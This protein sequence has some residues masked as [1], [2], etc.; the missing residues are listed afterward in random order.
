MGKVGAR[1]FAVLVVMA[2][3]FAGGCSDESGSGNQ[4]AKEKITTASRELTPN[5][6]SAAHILIAHTQ[7]ERAPAGITRSKEQALALAQE[8][9]E[10]ANA[11]DADFAEL[12]KEHSDG[13][14]G[15]RGG[16]AA[17]W[18]TFVPIKW[19]SRSQMRR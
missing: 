1:T 11:K 9:A 5:E 12:A 10:K 4:T 16:R 3:P 19:S 7:S 13:P 2:F 8:I 14:S 6:L 15:P 18:G 17:A